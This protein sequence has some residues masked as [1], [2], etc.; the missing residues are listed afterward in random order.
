MTALPSIFAPKSDDNEDVVSALETADIFWTKGDTDEALRWLKRAAETSSDAG[1]DMRALA[2]ARGAADLKSVPSSADVNPTVE[3]PSLRKSQLP[4]PPS[5]AARQ[6]PPPPSSVASS[7]EVLSLARTSGA[8]PK[9]PPPL[10]PSKARE[11][12]VPGAQSRA[13]AAPHPTPNTPTSSA[14]ARSASTDRMVAVTPDPRPAAARTSAQPAT[15]ATA[16]FTPAT[17]YRAIT[18]YVKPQGRDG[19]KLEVFVAEPGQPIPAGAEP[20][21]LVPTRRGGRL[22]G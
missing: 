15:T 6:P 3:P 5:S 12:I 10:P 16:A 20:A 2:I 7:G 13:P 19:D 22:L 17:A 8:P 9:S 11:S 21:I 4:T 1:N 14:P 18:V